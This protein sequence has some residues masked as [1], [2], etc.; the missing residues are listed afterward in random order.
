ML[1]NINKES[2]KPGIGL[3]VK[4]KPLIEGESKYTVF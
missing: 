1:G 2:K 3:F 4:K